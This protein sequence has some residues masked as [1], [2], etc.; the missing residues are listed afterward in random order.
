MYAVDFRD[1]HA[2]KLL[3]LVGAFHDVYLALDIDSSY[4]PSMY[5]YVH[6]RILSCGWRGEL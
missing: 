4:K 2:K 1:L 6:T 3:L 5:L